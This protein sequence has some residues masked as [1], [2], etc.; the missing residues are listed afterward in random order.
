M[1]MKFKMLSILMF[2]LMTWGM[3]GCNNGGQTND[4]DLPDEMGTAVI[5]I[6]EEGRYSEPAEVAEYIHTYKHLPPNYIT[7]K[8]AIALGWESNQGN[9]WEVTD[10]MSIGG[11]VF[12]NREKLLPDE[13]GR[14]WYECDVNYNG[15]YRGGER[16]AYSNDG[17][18][19]HTSDHYKTF[20]EITFP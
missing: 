19:Y 12:L 15:G 2:L 3:A 16:L 14:R 8:E 13:D 9:L 7:K 20:T 10:E 17:L 6:V 18:I 5:S 4:I 11:D 1:K